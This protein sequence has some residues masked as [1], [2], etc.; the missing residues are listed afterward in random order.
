MGS[1]YLAHDS[2]LDGPVALKIPRFASEREQEGISRFF[3]EARAAFRI[4][5]PGICPVYDV[6]EIEGQYF[7]SMA[8]IQG[9][10]L[11]SVKKPMGAKQAARIIR[12]LAQALQAAHRQGIT[13][14]DL[15]PANV[16]IDEEQNPIIMD[17]GLARRE[18]AEESRLTKTGAIV[19]TPCYMP[20]EQ[21]Q[22]K[23]DKIGPHTD[24]YS[25]G[26]MLYELLTGTLPFEGSAWEVLGQ[27]VTQ[28]P[29]PPSQRNPRVNPRLEAICLKAMAKQI[30]DRYASMAELSEALKGSFSAAETIAP[31]STI[32]DG[33]V[34]PAKK[35]DSSQCEQELTLPA[36]QTAATERVGAR[37]ASWC[38]S[39]MPRVAYRRMI[40]VLI[41]GCVATI[42]YPYWGP[43]KVDHNQAQPQEVAATVK[44][45]MTPAQL[46][47]GD[48]VVNS[49]GMV[50]VPIPAGEFQMGSPD[51]DSDA[52]ANEKPRHLVQITKP[53]YLSVYEVTQ[54]QYEKV[55]GVRPWRGHFLWSQVWVQEGTA[56]PATY[57]SH[58]DAVE[59][60]L[61][62][63]EQEGVEYR[64]PTEA[65][66][67][68]ACR[69]GSTTAYNFGDDVSKLG[70]HAW[71]F[72]N[73]CDVGEWYAH[74]VGQK[75]PNPWGLYDMHGNLSEWCQDGYAGYD[76]EKAVID[77]TGPA[78]GDH[79]M[80]R[81]GSIN[82]SPSILRS[83]KRSSEQRTYRSYSK[84]FRPARTY[85]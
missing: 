57:V 40:T 3:R 85:P 27:I 53:F 4:R 58:D 2:Q 64:L 48:P 84:G 9:H 63:S 56:H 44:K 45:H 28:Q 50:L 81:G 30:E 23:W 72:E 19:G 34:E 14:R 26:V 75:L 49:V 22:G 70:E 6:G 54:Q 38:K 36:P 61:K 52:F 11:S 21:V 10:T 79:R 68:Y 73:T 65:Q 7:I 32:P 78:Q 42:F 83:A 80:V 69:A 62:L 41:A 18:T 67:E 74:R 24:I 76:S 51:S 16:M 8:Y 46:A 82:N 33:T 43:T 5:H 47:L 31:A 37:F 39:C 25:L 20:I 55:M 1:V 17:F 66:W 13:H 35:A 59:F 29:E 71:C 77:P 60:C 12:Q 15:K